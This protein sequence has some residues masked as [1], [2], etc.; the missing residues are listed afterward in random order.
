MKVSGGSRNLIDTYTQLDHFYIK[1]LGL[2]FI[3]QNNKLRKS[4]LSVL[5][6][7]GDKCSCVKVDSR[8]WGNIWR[9]KDRMFAILNI[10]FQ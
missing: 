3:F 6:N 4:P 9:Q 1:P 5:L 10:S 2:L 7:I 8:Q